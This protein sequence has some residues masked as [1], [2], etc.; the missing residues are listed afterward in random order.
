MPETHTTPG[1]EPGT[2]CSTGTI[3][4]QP[5]CFIVNLLAIEPSDDTVGEKRFQLIPIRDV[6]APSRTANNQPLAP[7]V[8]GTPGHS[9]TV[10]S[11]WFVSPAW[12]T[13]RSVHC[14]MPY[15]SR[16]PCP[17]QTP[18]NRCQRQAIAG[19]RHC[20]FKVSAR[21]TIASGRRA[22]TMSW[23]HR[24]TGE[25]PRSETAFSDEDSVNVP[26]QVAQMRSGSGAHPH[27]ARLAQT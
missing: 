16:P 25:R 27:C 19:R 6:P 13:Q 2:S 7:N 22:D 8:I 21:G 3:P 23:P 10:G 15:A 24:S 11:T 26:D 12:P 20:T 14:R 5:K 9:G 4:R 18:A 17:H 1:L